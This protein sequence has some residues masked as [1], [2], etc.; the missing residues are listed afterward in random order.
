MYKIKNIENMS[1][2][3][4]TLTSGY[5]HWMYVSSTGCLTAGRSEAKYSIFPYVTDDLLHKNAHFTG[6]ITLI[7]CKKNNKKELWQ[8]FY[9]NGLFNNCERHLSKGPLGDQIIFEE[10]NHRLGL[11]F[12]YSWQCS[13]K[14]GFIRNSKIENISKKK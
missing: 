7:Q 2:F 5:D 10:I 12:S 13:E 14:F 3:L 11:R 9:S 6:P 1:P 8:P 4:M